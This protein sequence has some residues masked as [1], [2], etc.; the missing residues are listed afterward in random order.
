VKGAVIFA[1]RKFVPLHKFVPVLPP[2]FSLGHGSRFGKIA[3]RIFN[4][5][6]NFTAFG[7]SVSLDQI[8]WIIQIKIIFKWSNGVLTRDIQPINHYSSTPSLQN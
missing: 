4:F 7:K 3:Q 5:F 8:I 2:A 6:D 1:G